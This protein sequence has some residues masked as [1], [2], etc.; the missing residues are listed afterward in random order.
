MILVGSV[1]GYPVFVWLLKSTSQVLANSFTFIS[2]FI[3]LII[4]V[5]ILDEFISSFVIV[6]AA[7]M[8]LGSMATI[9]LINVKCSQNE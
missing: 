7:I 3:S 9:M 2:P 5:T 6:A 8:I 1:T 4:G